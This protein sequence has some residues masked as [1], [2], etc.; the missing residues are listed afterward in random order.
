MN[1]R[2]KCAALLLSVVGTL[3]ISQTNF[4]Q[5]PR[6]PD[7]IV[8]GTVTAIADDHATIKTAADEPFTVVFAADTS[9][10]KEVGTTFKMVPAKVTDIHVGNLIHVLGHLDP[11]GTTKHAKLVMILTAEMSQKVLAST[12]GI[13]V[14]NVNGPV[15]AIDGTKLTIARPDNVSQVIE[16]DEKTSFLKGPPRAVVQQ[17]MAAPNTASQAGV[18][19]ITLADVKVGDRIVASGALKFPATVALKDN[20]FLA[21]KFA[22]MFVPPQPN[23]DAAGAAPKQ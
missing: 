3:S 18:E 22:V 11:D 2:L 9:I 14:T 19:T 16:V 21:R 8:A 1:A 12:G 4:A 7:G 13:G 5:V 17:M 10:S 20:I 6:Q 15:T 23:A